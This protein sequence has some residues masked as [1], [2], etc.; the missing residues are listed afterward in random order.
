MI[1]RLKTIIFNKKFIFGVFLLVH[2]L[3]FNLNI[4]EWGDSYRMLTSSVYLKSGAYPAQKRP[5][6]FPLLLSLNPK[7]ID[8]VTWGRG[9]V[10][11]ISVFCYLLFCKL[12]D[13][14][15][16]KNTY[17]LLARMLFIF[18]PI[19]LYWSIRVMSDI[20]FSL[21]VLL[22]VYLYMTERKKLDIGRLILLG[23]IAGLAVLTRFEGYLLLAA[24]CLSVVVDTYFAGKAKGLKRVMST[25]WQSLNLILPLIFV[26]LLT[27]FLYLQ[28]N[29][30]LGSSYF[31]EPTGRVYDFK[32]VWV[33]L[34]SLIFGFGFTGA[35]Y[36]KLTN[37]RTSFHYLKEN[38]IVFFY[39]FFSL[40]LILMW[41]AAIPR[42]FTP[43]V[44]FYV[45]MIVLCMENAT[46]KHPTLRAKI[47]IPS[48]LLLVFVASQYVL[49][50]QF[51]VPIKSVFAVLVLLQAG[52]MVLD[53]FKHQ[54]LMMTTIVVSCMIWSVTV[55]YLHK[56]IYSALAQA[57]SYIKSNLIG[58]VAHNDT[59]GLLDWK[60]NH[61]R[62]KT[63]L[64]SF[65]ISDTVRIKDLI[66]KRF[67]Y[68]A[69]TN[70]DGVS[71]NIDSSELSKLN[72]VRDFRYN[73]AD[74]VFF[75]TIYRLKGVL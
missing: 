31:Q 4:S 74:K 57:S 72:K 66:K 38:L 10:L 68:L 9:V 23:F 29:P 69:L 3:L 32:M 6:L 73:I 59:V 65:Y 43:L 47:I 14:A 46:I 1:S 48:I 27:V 17:Q 2:V 64:R 40:A 35:F 11:V 34:A 13:L 42:L 37:I 18:N 49:K 67:D 44:P 51:L 24:V 39:L 28:S 21:W 15:I 56:G 19:Y 12:A 20:L 63:D 61:D 16:K 54:K 45:I 26:F 22:L 55:I 5:P 7:T 71:I 8:G 30:V 25:A 36:Y 53:V 50:L 58:S 62:P 70:E 41:P 33:F 60:I 52:I 75:V